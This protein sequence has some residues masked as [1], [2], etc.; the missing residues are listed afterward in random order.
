MEKERNKEQPKTKKNTGI[1]FTIIAIVL[2]AVFC[3]AL[4]PITLQNDTYY[5]IKIGEHI[6]QNGIDMQDPFSWHQDLS[7]TYPHWGYD[8]ITY[9]IYNMFGLTGIY[10][11]TCILSVILGI[12]IYFV[13]TRL[14][15]N[16][17]IS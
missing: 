3:V 14:T 11:A 4:T 16:K 13:N 12:S 1:K 9:L 2:I 15:K 6:L 7:Y 10:I 8:V 17:I 5:T